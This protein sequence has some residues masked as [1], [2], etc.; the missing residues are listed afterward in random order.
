MKLD[1]REIP[2]YYIN[3]D[4]HEEKNQ[5]MQ[6]VI[7]DFGFSNI[8]RISGTDM[9]NDPIAGCAS[10]HVEIFNLAKPP[11][12]ILEDD[13]EIYFNNPIINI[14]E[15]SDAI[16]LGLSSWALNNDAGMQ[17]IHSFKKNNEYQN[18][19][20]INNMLATHAILYLTKEYVDMCRR[21]GEY[22]IR[23]SVHIDVSFARFERFYNV[24]ALN[25]PVFYQSSNTQYT[26]IQ[27]DEIK[28][29]NYR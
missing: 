5:N 19:H 23:N 17:W 4:R 18:I 22:S 12:I 27:F 16:Y 3:L 9:P 2:T 8:K 11:F 28:L 10:S 20:K 1:L 6:K 7:K 29:N 15:N 13:C 21:A 14:P 26:K 24:Y 25:Q